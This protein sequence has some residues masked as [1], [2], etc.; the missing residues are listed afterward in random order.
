MMYHPEARLTIRAC[1]NFP[2]WGIGRD[3]RLYYPAYQRQ[4]NLVRPLGTGIFLVPTWRTFMV[5]V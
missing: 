2:P 1:F 5:F 3:G 4:P